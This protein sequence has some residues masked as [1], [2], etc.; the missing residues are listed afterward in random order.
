MLN[1]I[2]WEKPLNISK[3][4]SPLAFSNPN[5]KNNDGNENNAYQTKKKK[6]PK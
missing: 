2:E 5:G 1:H 6:C 3:Y 4:N